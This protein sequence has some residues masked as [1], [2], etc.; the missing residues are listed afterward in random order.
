MENKDIFLLL[1][2]LQEKLHSSLFSQI[3]QLRHIMTEA[4]K[5]P[6]HITHFCRNMDRFLLVLLATKLAS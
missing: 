2:D 5:V 3:T 4:E 1:Y 6:T